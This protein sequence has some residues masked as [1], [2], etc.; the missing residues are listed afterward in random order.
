MAYT[1]AIK[2]LTRAGISASIRWSGSKV[3]RGK[4]GKGALVTL[5]ESGAVKVEYV[6]TDSLRSSTLTK[7]SDALKAR[8]AQV[9]RMPNYLLVSAAA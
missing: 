6:G 9:K 8:G 1:P 7:Y 3:K 2:K 4:K 5:T